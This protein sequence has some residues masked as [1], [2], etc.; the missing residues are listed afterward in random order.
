MNIFVLDPC[1]VKSVKSYC[2]KHIN[3]MITESVQM[4]GFCSSKYLKEDINTEFPGVGKSHENHPCVKWLLESKGNYEYLWDLAQFMGIEY[5]YRERKDPNEHKSY[6]ILN[7]LPRTIREMPDKGL[8]KFVNCTKSFKDIPDV[9]EAYRL[10]YIFDKCRFV[11][12]KRRL[13]PVWAEVR[14]I[15][16]SPIQDR[17]KFTEFV[18]DRDVKLRKYE[19]WN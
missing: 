5:S 7:K 11:T 8:T 19:A 17:Y 9:V 18:T 1:I 2:D 3:K 13:P 16:Y 6:R 14:K 4:L 15:S 12:W 10:S